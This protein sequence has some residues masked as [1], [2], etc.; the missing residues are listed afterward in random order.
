MA[1]ALS[2]QPRQEPLDMEDAEPTEI[3]APRRVVSPEDPN[4]AEERHTSSQDMLAFVLGA[5]IV[6]E[7]ETMKLRILL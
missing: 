5:R 2:S 7:D 1:E 4:I 6:S 3:R